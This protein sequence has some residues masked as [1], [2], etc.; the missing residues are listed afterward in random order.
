MVSVLTRAWTAKPRRHTRRVD[1]ELPE[2]PSA[3]ELDLETDEVEPRHLLGDGMLHLE[4]RIGLDERERGSVA[5]RAGHDQELDRAE[6]VEP[7][8][9]R[10]PE[11]GVEQEG[12]QAVRQPGRGRDL[13]ELLMAPLERAVALPEVAH[14]AGAVAEHLHLDVTRPR[15][16]LLDVEI[17][18]AERLQRFGAAPRPRS[19]TSSGAV[20]TR[21]PRPPPPATALMTAPLPGPSEARNARALFG[22]ASVAVPG[23]T[24]TPQAAA[25]ARARAL[26]PK[27]ASTFA[28][29]PTNAIPMSAHRPANAAFSARKP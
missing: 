24:G 4:P 28:R 20:T 11:R 25:R 6:V 27:S 2:R 18:G 9:A 14:G 19:S 8:L 10:D 12:A 26:S 29:G 17:A 1:R 23:R 3:R 16:Q 15:R 7:D 5:L 21:I 13:H 22:D